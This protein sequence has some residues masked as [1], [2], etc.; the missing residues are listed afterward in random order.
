VSSV[1]HQVSLEEK[2][3]QLLYAYTG[4]SPE[5]IRRQVAQGKLGGLF[6]LESD[7][8]D[9]RVAAQFTA[10]MQ[11]M[12][13]RPLFFMVDAEAGFGQQV[14]ESATVFPSPMGIGATRNVDYAYQCGRISAIEAKLLGVQAFCCPVLDVNSDP[15]NPVIA[16]RSFGESPELVADMGEAFMRGAQEQGVLATGKHFPGHGS[17]SVDSHLDLPRCTRER[18]GLDRIELFPYR[19]AIAGGLRA[20]MTAHIVFPALE[21]SPTLPATLSPAIMTGLVRRELG[22]TG[23]LISDG[24][25]MKGITA[26]FSMDDAMIRCINAG[27]DML[28][29]DDADEGV[30]VLSEAVVSGKIARERIEEAVA[31][32]AVAKEAMG[33]AVRPPAPDGTWKTIVGCEEH[34]NVARSAAREAITVV[35][36]ERGMLPLRL[37]SSDRVCVLAETYRLQARD[38]FFDGMRSRHPNTACFHLTGGV[39]H[40]MLDDRGAM[41]NAEGADDPGAA[42]ERVLAEVR[43]SEAV[44]IGTW[45]GAYYETRIPA[46]HV[47]LRAAIEECLRQKKKLIVIAFSN[48]YLLRVYPEIPAYLC[49]Y[50]LAPRCIDSV[51]AAI[52]VIFGERKPTGRLPVTLIEGRYE[53][54]HGLADL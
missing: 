52:E 30:R 32:I 9:P 5:A 41:G 20:I 8:P 4:N 19:R 23:L 48:P 11:R 44:V 3:G 46:M 17:T 49:A 15:D 47:A 34:R 16:A 6:L 7:M 1:P 39:K 27:V 42:R 29:V 12:A 51:A 24:L 14:G 50:V 2:I 31:R 45:A 54:G 13:P 43:R 26:Y 25:G 10:E 21:P 35:R 28:L 33:L 53:Y 22:F 36:N 37:S 40:G 18:E 38:A